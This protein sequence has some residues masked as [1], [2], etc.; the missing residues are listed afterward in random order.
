MAVERIERP[1]LITGSELINGIS[2]RGY[3]YSNKEGMIKNEL[4]NIISGVLEEEIQS[5][6]NRTLD[7][8]AKGFKDPKDLYLFLKKY[9]GLVIPHKVNCDSKDHCAPFQYVSDAVLG[10]VMNMLII[11]NRGGAKSFNAGLIQWLLANMHPMYESR[12][13][14]GSGEQSMR[15]YEAMLKIDDDNG[16]KARVI[17]DI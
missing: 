6:T 4:F 5:C 2:S 16:Y 12:I 7:R 10:I 8:I 1:V 13:L 9:L 15:S 11:G 3:S 14:G 17:F